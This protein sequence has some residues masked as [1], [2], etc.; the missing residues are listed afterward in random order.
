MRRGVVRGFQ[1]NVRG[2]TLQAQRWTSL[3]STPILKAQRRDSSEQTSEAEAAACTPHSFAAA[4]FAARVD[5]CETHP[6]PA[7]IRFDEDSLD[8]LKQLI[9][10]TLDRA[11]AGA[12]RTAPLALSPEEHINLLSCGIPEVLG[13][14]GLESYAQAT[15]FHALGA[16]CTLAPMIASWVIDAIRVVAL[17]NDNGTPQQK[18]RWFPM[19]TDGKLLVAFGDAGTTGGTDLQ[20]VTATATV[21]TEARAGRIADDAADAAPTTP[22]APEPHRY[23]INASKCWTSLS[24]GAGL[25]KSA[26][27]MLVLAATATQV[28]TLSA[29]DNSRPTLE[30]RLTWFMVDLVKQRPG[31]VTRTVERDSITVTLR[32]AHVTIEDM[33]GTCGEGAPIHAATVFRSA[34]AIL[35]AVV[36]AAQSL[37]EL[38]RRGPPSAVA[39]VINPS[40]RFTADVFATQVTGLE[41]LVAVVAANFHRRVP[42]ALAD[43]LACIIAAH[44]V[45][46][47]AQRLVSQ[48]VKSTRDSHLDAVPRGSEEWRA[49]V[50]THLDTIRSIA[51]ACGSADT[52][53]LILGCLG[54]EDYALS[55]IKQSS[56][57]LMGIRTQREVEKKR[58][59]VL[60]KAT[61]H[62]CE[63][64]EKLVVRYG[65]QSTDRQMTL[66]RVADACSQLTA[67]NA[68]SARKAAAGKAASSGEAFTGT[69][70]QSDVAE[71][72]FISLANETS[73]D[74]TRSGRHA[75]ESRA[76]LALETVHQLM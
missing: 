44:D 1:S 26:T 60:T 38:F 8:T 66:A 27:H 28:Q 36:A 42:D 50:F 22:A 64:T 69:R 6:C 62:L 24:G 18:A 13:G 49:A 48:L 63:A 23:R 12:G 19:M 15:L 30:E 46:D 68:I 45:A 29:G 52:C 55:F 14:L 51:S 4:A 16:N 72:V 33:V 57:A 75:D 9:A 7:P 31:V 40:L 17:I 54:A 25:A 39:T 71:S 10:S 32:D 43:S 41:S 2:V 21:E 11:A 74:V 61:I 59:D 58:A 53:Q 37:V 65:A 67:A 3:C 56:F 76:V 34:P 73:F 70:L 35:S 5:R 47:E 20:E